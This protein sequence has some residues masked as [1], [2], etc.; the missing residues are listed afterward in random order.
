MSHACATVCIQVPT[1][2]IICPL[3]KSWKLRW[4][5]AR[6]MPAARPC[7]AAPGEGAVPDCRSTVDGGE[8][9]ISCEAI[10][11]CIAGTV[12]HVAQPLLAKLFSRLIACRIVDL[13]LQ[14]RTAKWSEPL[15]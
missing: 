7:P 12:R 3:K 13:R 5:S 10:F 11:Y 8:S 1:R 15:F 9:A 14:K 2:E 4:R 6:N